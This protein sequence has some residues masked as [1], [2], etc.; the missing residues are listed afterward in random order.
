MTRTSAAVTVAAALLTLVAWGAGGAP[1]EP[2]PGL[3][4]VVRIKQFEFIPASIAIPAGRAVRWV[5][6]DVAAHQI[7]TGAVVGKQVRSNGRVSSPQFF[8]SEAVAV[9]FSTPGEYPY[10]CGIHPF[11][12]GT[13]VVR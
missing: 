9:V 12:R 11:M 4:A 2:A 3:A 7:T 1:L 6:E 8:R 5:N 13:V 10:Y